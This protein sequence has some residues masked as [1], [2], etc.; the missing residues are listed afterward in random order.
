MLDWQS[1]IA[2]VPQDIYLIDGTIAQNIALGIEKDRID[3]NKLEEVSRIAN[4]L[5]FVNSLP[6]RFNTSVGERGFFL[7]GGQK[8][9]IGLARALYKSPQVL[10][11]DEATSALDNQ[12]ETEI[13]ENLAK[14]KNTMTIFLITHKPLLLSACDE[15]YEMKNQSSCKISDIN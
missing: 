9:R 4:I 7:S 12:S 2:H 14:I 10:F 1:S 3:L 15:I 8:Q 13:M 5:G 6:N 11:L